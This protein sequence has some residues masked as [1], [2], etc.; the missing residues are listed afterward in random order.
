MASAQNEGGDFP[1]LAQRLLARSKTQLS[2]VR[3]VLSDP[4]TSISDVFAAARPT[5]P[6]AAYAPTVEAFLGP[7][8]V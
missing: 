4:T 7:T 2:Q 1:G 8:A 5:N 6:L 3:K